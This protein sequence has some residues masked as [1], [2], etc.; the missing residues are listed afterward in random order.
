MNFLDLLHAAASVTGIVVLQVC[1][2]F[3]FGLIVPHI[4]C[5]LVL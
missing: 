2:L 3:S 1:S 5:I 4:G